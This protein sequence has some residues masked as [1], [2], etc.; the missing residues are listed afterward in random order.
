[1]H[2]WLGT[3]GYSYPDWVGK[4]YPRG[5]SPNRMLASY[6]RSF[7]LVELNFAYY[8]VPTPAM[9]A[10]M[11]GQTPDGFQFLVKLHRSLSHEQDPRADVLVNQKLIEVVAEHLWGEHERP[12]QPVECVH[13]LPAVLERHG[14]DVEKERLVVD[15]R[16]ALA[17]PHD[18]ALGLHELLVARQ[19]ERGRERVGHADLDV[20]ERRGAVL[21]GR[22]V[23]ARVR[24]AREHEGCGCHGG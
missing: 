6:A 14:V 4:F 2:V 8:R 3:S 12:R 15:E 5:T 13:E 16:G 10:R 22:C 23:R 18:L 17:L 20:I 7:P 1:M 24:A 19:R 9:L 11:A 21:G